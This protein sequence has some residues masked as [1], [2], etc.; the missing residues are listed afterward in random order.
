[1]NV[2]QLRVADDFNLTNRADLGQLATSSENQRWIDFYDTT[3]K[4]A[5][6]PVWIKKT[7]AEEGQYVGS[8]QWISLTQDANGNPTD[9][10]EG[11]FLTCA[12]NVMDVNP[13]TQLHEYFPEIYIDHSGS[14]YRV[15]PSWMIYDAVADV[16]LMRTQITITNAN[17]VLKLANLTTDEP[18]TGQEVY[19]CGFPGGHDV[20]SLTKGIIRDAHFNIKDGGQ[21]VDSLFINAPGIGGNSGSAM[22]NEAGD[23]IG[24]YTFGYTDHETFAGGINLRCL[25]LVIDKLKPLIEGGT[26][27]RFADKNFLGLDW[28]RPSPITE[29]SRFPVADTG[30]QVIYNIMPHQGCKVSAVDAGSSLGGLF[31]VGDILMSATAADGT[32]WDFGYQEGQRTPGVMI[33]HPNLTPVTIQYIRGS[34]IQSVS[35]PTC[36]QYSAVA[37]NEDLYL[38]GGNQNILQKSATRVS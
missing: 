6:S 13:S 33:H 36:T 38:I 3:V 32:A 34:V 4:H 22:L 35:V 25:S 9:L 7:G 20:D 10:A 28:N 11:W 12:H 1:M 16:C 24:V 31:Q 26:T 14:W 8:G 21:A 17:H 23:I 15:D 27:G 29:Q 5:C 2:P 37:Q 18:V 19:M 30:G